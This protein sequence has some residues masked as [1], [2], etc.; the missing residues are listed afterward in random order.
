MDKFNKL[1]EAVR[2]KKVRELSPKKVRFSPEFM[3]ALRKEYW[4]QHSM[5]GVNEVNRNFLKAISFGL[6]AIIKDPPATGDDGM[7][8]YGD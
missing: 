6:D 1:I 4:D 3:D 8:E 2:Y 7:A 5:L